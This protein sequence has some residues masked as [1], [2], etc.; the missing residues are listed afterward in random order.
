MIITVQALNLVLVTF[1]SKSTCL[2]FIVET[3]RY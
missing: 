2:V 3:D 1:A